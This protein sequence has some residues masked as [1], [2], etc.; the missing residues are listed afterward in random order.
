MCFVVGCVY[1]PIKMDKIVLVYLF[2]Y[3]YMFSYCTAVDGY[4]AR[5]KAG[6]AP[7]SGITVNYGSYLPTGRVCLLLV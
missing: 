3:F 2:I 6:I 7:F 1:F 5:K 4:Q